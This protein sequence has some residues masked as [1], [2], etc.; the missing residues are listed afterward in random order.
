MEKTVRMLAAIMFTDIVGYTKLM[1]QNEDYAK[2]LRDKNRKVLDEIIS[3]HH[4]RILEY[5][6]DGTLSVFG[7]VVEAVSAASKIQN[8]LQVEPVV[9]MRIGIHLG[10]IVYE[11][12]GVYGDGVNI[13][14]RIEN[15]GIEGS[16]LFSGKVNEELINHPKFQTVSLGSYKLKNVIFPIEIFALTNSPHKYPSK[17]FL[18]NKFAVSHNSIAVL[19]FVNMSSDSENEYFSDG[20]TEEIL[21]SLAQVKEIQ[22]T[23]RT[24]S[25]KFKNKKADIRTIGN[26]LNV[27]TIL[28][29]SVRKAGKRVRITAQLIKTEDGYHIWS[30]TYDREIND[31]FALQDEISQEIVKNLCKELK[32]GDLVQYSC[33]SHQTDI[34]AYN[35]YL[36]GIYLTNKMSPDKIEDAISVFEESLKLDDKYPLT[37]AKLAYCY[38]FL[39]TIGYMQPDIAYPKS[40]KYCHYAL[41]LDQNLPDAH[42][43]IALSKMFFEWNWKEAEES[44]NH[45]LN[46]NPDLAIAHQYYAIFLLLMDR[47]NE[48]IKNAEKAFELDPLSFPVQCT[49]A[50]VLKQ[51][52]RIEEAEKIY[53]N[54]LELDPTFRTALNSLGWLYISQ[55]KYEKAEKLFLRSKEL[56]GHPIRGITSLCFLYAVTDRKEKALE[57]LEL[58]KQRSIV[59]ENV[60]LHL[61]FAI[62]Y[63]GLGEINRAFDYL[64]KAYDEKYGGLIFIKFNHWK[65]LFNY[66]RYEN[67]ISKLNLEK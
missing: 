59:E 9:P 65:K 8:A 58:L 22:V 62:C 63:I 25:F 2:K 45:A 56:V 21:N 55:E 12:D 10:D 29:G 28:E 4:G 5:F 44:F 42:L 60:M 54:V 32:I 50:D 53:K 34:D 13:A 64:E 40:R 27:D 48:A 57:M 38:G 6:G 26:E 49:L 11:D 47:N 24:S 51:S 35:L 41:G 46:L 33:K 14:S 43:V 37:Y 3:G 19:P 15:M 61:D 67:L 1:Q 7:S 66:K 52:N 36:K 30:N 16:I 31:I 20:I 23:S 18:Q 39:G 17:N